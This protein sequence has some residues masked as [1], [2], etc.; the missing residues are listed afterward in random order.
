MISLGFNTFQDVRGGLSLYLWIHVLDNEML[1]VVPMR[2]FC[3]NCGWSRAIA[4]EDPLKRTSTASRCAQSTYASRHNRS[5]RTDPDGCATGVS[6]LL[7]R[8]RSMALPCIVI[9]IYGR[10]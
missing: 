3:W 7:D 10:W 4:Y 1:V 8:L 5:R 9:A 2:N 6:I